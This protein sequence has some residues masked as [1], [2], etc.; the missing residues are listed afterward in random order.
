MYAIRS[1]YVRRVLEGDNA[2]EGDVETQFQRL[3]G[4]APILGETVHHPADR[5]RPL[6]PQDGDGVCPGIPGMDDQGPGRRPGGA[7]SYN[8]V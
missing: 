5:I 6:L 3:L 2:G 4:H 1:Y 7:D 8:F